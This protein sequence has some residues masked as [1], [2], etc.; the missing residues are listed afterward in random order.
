[1]L[2]KL[3]KMTQMKQKNDENLFP[4]DTLFKEYSTIVMV[5]PQ[6]FFDTL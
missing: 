3:L 6:I 5:F 1:M 4:L 2:Q